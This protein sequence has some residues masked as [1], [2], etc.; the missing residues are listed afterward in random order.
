[1]N[2]QLNTGL[3]IQD[4]LA[5]KREKI[6]QLARQHGVTNV[7]VFGSVARGEARPDSDIDLLVDQDWTRLSR[8]GG[9]E[10]VVALEDL[11]GRKVDVTTV[12][13]LKPRIRARV[14]HEAVPL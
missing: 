4:L 1:M 5:D 8:W 9:M 7:R 13:E 3:G 14:L 12:E 11:L 6:L 2:P 10:F